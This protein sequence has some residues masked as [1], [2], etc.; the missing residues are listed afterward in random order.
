MT[1]LRSNIQ[2][3]QEQFEN[4]HSVLLNV[5]ERLSGIS[6]PVA[7]S[8]IQDLSKL[9]NSIQDLQDKVSAKSQTQ[10]RQLDALVGVGHTINSSLGRKAVLDR[11]MDIV[12]DLMQAERGLIMLRDESG[13]LNV[14][15]ARGMDQVDLNGND[16]LVSKTIV[17]RVMETGEQVLIA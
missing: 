14:D 10:Q 17:Q 11:V 5:M 8:V 9:T 15:A 4:F 3:T 16:F 2:S 7:S 12:I 1:N 13:E 6:N